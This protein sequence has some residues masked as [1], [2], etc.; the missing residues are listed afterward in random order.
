M[1]VWTFYAPSLL[2]VSIEGQTENKGKMI[3]VTAFVCQKFDAQICFLLAC[4]YCQK[5]LKMKIIIKKDI[6]FIQKSLIKERLPKN[7]AP[8]LK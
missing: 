5:Q 6:V 8:L 3:A 4:M 7:K 2:Y 1:T